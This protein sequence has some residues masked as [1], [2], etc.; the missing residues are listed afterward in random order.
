MKQELEL[1]FLYLSNPRVGTWLEELSG[2]TELRQ[3][4]LLRLAG[5]ATPPPSFFEQLTC[6]RQLRV[7]EL[8]PGVYG[9]IAG[10]DMDMMH[11]DAGG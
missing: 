10:F 6:L 11:G 7:L 4:R 8:L 3:L 2:V 5:G 9:Q 1:R